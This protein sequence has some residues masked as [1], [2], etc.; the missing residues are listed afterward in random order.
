MART[1]SRETEAFAPVVTAASFLARSRD[2]EHGTVPRLELLDGREVARPAPAA[3]AAGVLARLE[4]K[5]ARVAAR[6]PRLAPGVVGPLSARA[7]PLL[8]IGPRDVLR[9]D[10][11]LIATGG[12]GAVRLGGSFDAVDVLLA[13]EAVPSSSWPEH[14][15]PRYATVGLPEVWLLDLDQGWVE[16]LR[17]PWSGRFHSRTLW[18]P[19][20]AIPVARLWSVA[21]EALPGP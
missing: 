9:P 21:I 4:R 11:A 8:R 5:L 19:G 1:G 13:V 6:G 2:G 10:L 15:L 12:A 7:R 3:P 14:R 18:Y 20:E 17:S 16:A